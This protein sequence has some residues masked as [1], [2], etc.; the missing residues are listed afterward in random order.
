MKE[1]QGQHL[2]FLSVKHDGDKIAHKGIYSA[3]SS[4][5]SWFVGNN[6]FVDTLN[7]VEYFKRRVGPWGTKL[8]TPAKFSGNVCFQLVMMPKSTHCVAIQTRHPADDIY[9]TIDVGDVVQVISDNKWQWALGT[10]WYDAR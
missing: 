9:L 10:G 7:L 8:A 5:F 6:Q 3:N 4:Y 2:F 1:K